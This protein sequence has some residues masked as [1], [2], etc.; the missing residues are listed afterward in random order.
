MHST[1]KFSMLKPEFTFVM[2]VGLLLWTTQ[3]FHLF[4]KKQLNVI[5]PNT[6][7]IF[8]KLEHIAHE[9]LKI[10]SLL[11]SDFLSYV[12]CLHFPHSWI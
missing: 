10:T 5:I 7:V 2:Y 11:D 9:L 4:D 3:N 6:Y 12:A 1:L 8:F